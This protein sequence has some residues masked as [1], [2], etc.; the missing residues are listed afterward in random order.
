MAELGKQDSADATCIVLLL[1][2]KAPH[3]LSMPGNHGFYK[4]QGTLSHAG[5][6]VSSVSGM[7]YF[8]LAQMDFTQPNCTY[9]DLAL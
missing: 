8:N 2:P 5:D 6:V 1:V 7:R 9:H 3:D 4:V